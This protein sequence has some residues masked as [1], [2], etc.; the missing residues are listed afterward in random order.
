MDILLAE[1]HIHLA[2]EAGPIHLVVQADR[3]PVVAH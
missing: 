3:S 2:A 1:V